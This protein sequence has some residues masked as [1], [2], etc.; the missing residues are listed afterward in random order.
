MSLLD[1]YIV[2]AK[3]PAIVHRDEGIRDTITQR[4]HNFCS[5]CGANMMPV[6]GWAGEGEFDTVTGHPLRRAWKMAACCTWWMTEEEHKITVA[7]N[8][9]SMML[10][11]PLYS[12]RSH[13]PHNLILLAHEPVEIIDWPDKAADVRAVVETEVRGL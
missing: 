7:R 2:K 8:P 9:Y 11:R 1:K 4:P 6:L 5:K 12:I 10:E 13:H 3:S